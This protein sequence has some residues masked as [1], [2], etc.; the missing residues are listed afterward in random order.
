MVKEHLL[1]PILQRVAHV[2]GGS[3]VR[4]RRQRV[5][6][7][8]MFHGID[9]RDYPVEV[10]EAQLAY[11]AQRFTIVPLSVLVQHVANPNGGASVSGEI[12]ITFDDGLR[13]N[14]TVAYPVLRRL[15]LPATFFV[16][17]GLIEQRR[18][19]WTHDVVERLKS[20]DETQRAGIARDVGAPSAS[21]EA[22][23][24]W[25][26]TIPSRRRKTVEED[27]RARTPRFA[28][29]EDQRRRFDPM[30]WDELGS[31]DPGLVTVG[32]HTLTHPMLA[33]LPPAEAAVEIH[34]SRRWLETHLGRPIEYFC[35]PDGAHNPSVVTMV[36]ESYRAAVTTVPGF[37]RA[38]DDLYR[39]QR[40][41][42]TREP[43]LLAW[44]LHRPSA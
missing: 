33:T 23:K 41:P 27:V 25:L 12:A 15:R 40:I 37:I 6:R 11:L 21:V 3:A 14:Y 26:K 42:A 39:L 16:C 36:Q 34:E 7:I 1:A 28:P 8:L 24:E 35:Y 4:A 2:S 32:S 30:T 5:G 17:P 13:N 22:I 29:T 38:G 31:L 9:G 18:W 44:R 19:L 20:L 43:S 10:F